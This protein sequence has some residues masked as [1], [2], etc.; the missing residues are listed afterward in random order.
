MDYNKIFSYDP[1]KVKKLD[2]VPSR[3]IARWNK[4]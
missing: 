1:L 3:Y 4:F 2:V